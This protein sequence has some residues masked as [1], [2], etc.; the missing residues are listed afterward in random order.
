M[1][2]IR[3]LLNRIGTAPGACHAAAGRRVSLWL[4]TVRGAQNGNG[5]I[6]KGESKGAVCGDARVYWS[7]AK[8]SL[9][10]R[11]DFWGI[12][13]TVPASFAGTAW[14]APAICTRAAQPGVSPP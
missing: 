7:G 11:A 6:G 1:C 13:L 3:A 4:R 5:S 9:M 10:A 2:E 14:I 12:S 8:A